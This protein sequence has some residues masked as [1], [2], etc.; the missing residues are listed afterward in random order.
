MVPGHSLH[1]PGHPRMHLHS[2][3]SMHAMEMPWSELQSLHLHLYVCMKKTG[4][5]HS[6]SDIQR[7]FTNLGSAVS[8]CHR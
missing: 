1:V 6:S 2:A 4:P 7:I 5:G 8:S 3:G